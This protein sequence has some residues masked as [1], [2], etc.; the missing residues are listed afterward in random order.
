MMDASLLLGFLA[1]ALLAYASPGPDWFVV[2]RSAAHSRRNGL[3]SSL[4]LI[5]GLAVHTIAASIGVSALLLASAEAFALVKLAGALYLGFLGIRALQSAYRTWKHP[6]GAADETPERDAGPAIKV[7]ASAFAANVLNPKAALFFVAVLPQFVTESAP[8]LP[9]ILLLGGADILLG[10]VFWAAF[11]LTVAR[12][13]TLLQ[14]R[15]ARIALDTASGTALIGLGCALAL[16]S[17]TT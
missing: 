2:L 12:F 4:G 10:C 5:T 9:Q 16:T 13:R 15:R 1:V 6:Q 8:V 11:T 3:L 7:W 14:R 17:R